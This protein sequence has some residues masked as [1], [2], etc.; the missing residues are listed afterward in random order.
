MEKGSRE[1]TPHPEQKQVLRPRRLILTNAIKFGI[2]IALTNLL[3]Y[4][5]TRH[6]F[7]NTAKNYVAKPINYV[8]RLGSAMW[9]TPYN[10]EQVTNEASKPSPTPVCK[11]EQQK[12]YQPKS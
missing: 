8:R 11:S 4:S 5:I 6:G 1:V 9:N 12:N 10:P 7:K 2:P 3:T